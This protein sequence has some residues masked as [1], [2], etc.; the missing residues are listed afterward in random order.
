MAITQLERS[1]ENN[2]SDSIEDPR[3]AET[4]KQLKKPKINAADDSILKNLHGWMMARSK[5]VKIHS[6][7][8]ATTE[9]MVSYLTPH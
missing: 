8:G 6:F 2:A 3:K 7:P 4:T 5:S 9:E 1:G